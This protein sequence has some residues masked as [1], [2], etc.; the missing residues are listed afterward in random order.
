[1]QALVVLEIKGGNEEELWPALSKIK[2][3]DAVLFLEGGGAIVKAS[4]PDI[5]DLTEA[6]KL[7]R[8]VPQ[9]R[10]TETRIVLGKLEGNPSQP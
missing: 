7:M 8:S 1:M 5:A 2:G 9:V 10:S 6:V 3:V 4:F